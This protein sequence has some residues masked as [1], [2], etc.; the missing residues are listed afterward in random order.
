MLHNYY[1]LLYKKE[2]SN[3]ENR[4]TKK[5]AFGLFLKI[6]RYKRNRS[7]DTKATKLTN[8]SMLLLILEKDKIL[9]LIAGLSCQL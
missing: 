9:Y 6:Y 1:V 4:S 3:F 7:Q 2:F 5:I 8:N